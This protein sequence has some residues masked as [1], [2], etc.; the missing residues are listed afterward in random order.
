LGGFKLWD[1]L[2][3]FFVIGDA[4]V[5][6]STSQHWI[7]FHQTKISITLFLRL[8]SQKSSTGHKSNVA[9]SVCLFFFKWSAS[10]YSFFWSVLKNYTSLCNLHLKSLGT[11]SVCVRRRPKLI[12]RFNFNNDFNLR[13]TTSETVWRKVCYEL[14]YGHTMYT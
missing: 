14:R 7:F 6:K 11:S 5:N 1:A 8:N 12:T 9:I 4:L 2:C 10:I 3:F 13:I